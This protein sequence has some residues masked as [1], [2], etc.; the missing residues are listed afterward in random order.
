M[1][2]ARTVTGPLVHATG[3]PVQ[4]LVPESLERLT[5]RV[6]VVDDRVGAASREG[7]WS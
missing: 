4:N 7:R 5:M 2:Q 3:P 6:L 1:Y